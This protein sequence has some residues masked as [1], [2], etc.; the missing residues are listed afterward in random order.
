MLPRVRARLQLTVCA[1]SC[2][3]SPWDDM[4]RRD[5]RQL[6]TLLFLLLFAGILKGESLRRHFGFRREHGFPS[7][8]EL[9]RCVYRTL[10]NYRGILEMPVDIDFSSHALVLYI[11]A[12]IY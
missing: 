8:H 7:F 10:R 11:L 12:S 5:H 6:C 3:V 4:A 1:L 2:V 9:T